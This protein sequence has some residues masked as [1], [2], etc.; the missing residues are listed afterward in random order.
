MV[1]KTHR[2]NNDGKKIYVEPL[3]EKHHDMEEKPLAVYKIQTTLNPECKIGGTGGGGGGYKNRIN[4]IRFPTLGKFKVFLENHVPYWKKR[5]I[6]DPGSDVF[7]RWNRV[8]L[9]SCILSL[10]I[11]P[12]FFYLHKVVAIAND[13]GNSSSCMATDLKLVTVVALFRTFADAFYL[14]NV[15]VKFRT[16]YVSPS[17][18]VFGKGELVMDPELIARRYLTSEFFLDYILALPLP[19]VPQLLE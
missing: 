17:S 5:I 15:A 8:F 10:F 9:F 2:F 19:Q 12:L 14:L 13:D 18:R 4:I 11:D 1:L 7:L 6:I 3:W 16:A